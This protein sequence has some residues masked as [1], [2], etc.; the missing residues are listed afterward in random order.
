MLFKVAATKDSSAMWWVTELNMAM[1]GFYG[2]ENSLHHLHLCVDGSWKRK[3]RQTLELEKV[4][5]ISL[6]SHYDVDEV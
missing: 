5:I 3:K 2:P 4:L 6:F 1:M